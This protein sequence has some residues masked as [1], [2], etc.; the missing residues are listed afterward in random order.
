MSPSTLSSLTLAVGASPL[1]ALAVKASLAMAV[2]L[3]LIRGARGASAALR[4]AVAAASFVVLLLLPLT[5]LL[6]PARVIRVDVDAPGVR[7]AEAP[8]KTEVAR[9]PAHAA[10]A[11]TDT[12]EASSW[13]ID[14]RQVAAGVYATGAMLVGAAL[15]RGL[16]RVRRIRR[17]AQVSVPGTLLANGMARAEAGRAGIEVA[18]SPELPVPITLGWQHPVILL[19]AE[20][21]AWDEAA[22]RRAVR[23]EL[24]HIMRADSAT[25]I[26]SRLAVA[27][28]WPHPFAWMLWSRLRLEAE[29]ACDDAVI[30][31][32]GEAV[33]YAEQLVA[34]ARRVGDAQPVPVLAMATRSNLGLR[35][36]AILDGKRR[37]GARSRLASVTVGALALAL[38]WAIAPVRVMARVVEPPP[39]PENADRSDDDAKDDE[40][41]DSR[42]VAL[43]EAAEKGALAKMQKLL[44]EGA[45]ADAAISGDG[46]PL[47][48]AAR[49]GRLDAIKL[50][51]ASGAKVNRGVGGDG[52]PLIMAAKEGHLEAVRLLLDEGADIDLGVRGDGNAL[53]M[54]AGAGRLDVMRLLLDRGA[55]IEKIVPGDENPLIHASEAGE[56]AAVRLL[57]DRGADVHARAWAGTGNDRGEWRTAL[58]MARR[59]GHQA[60]V[61]ILLEA[62]ARE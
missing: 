56:A 29:R 16:W 60:V 10:A 47:I 42:D 46:S 40:G 26:L 21:A 1:A 57:L 13:R 31:S 4:H 53:I 17:Q 2:A 41:K 33:P 6:A 35:V 20:A 7:G 51:I 43:L 58:K 55:S 49:A 30:R 62:G 27:L 15:L 39:V 45:R 32:Q 50:L 54:A 38:L 28:Y 25:Q 14:P 18:F 48:A 11:A 9:G 23:H 22:L 5:A 19:P 37:R 12:R 34:L 61:R 8:P 59:N 24:E 52:S 3:L 36:E 44:D